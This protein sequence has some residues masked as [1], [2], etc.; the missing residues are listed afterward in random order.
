MFTDEPAAKTPSLSGV[1]VVKTHPGNHRRGAKSTLTNGEKNVT[2]QGVVSWEENF[3]KCNFL[4][5]GEVKEALQPL[6]LLQGRSHRAA[7]I[8][9]SVHWS[10]AAD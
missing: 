2:N 3:Q 7:V 4:K 6:P 5:R 8:Y 9:V 10:H 1:L